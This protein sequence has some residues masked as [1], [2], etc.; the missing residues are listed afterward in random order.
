VAT[1][2]KIAAFMLLCGSLW[3]Q[4]P[5]LK[6]RPQISYAPIRDEQPVHRNLHWKRRLFEAGTGA[7]AA[8]LA[9]DACDGIIGAKKA[10]YVGAA[11]FVL[12]FGIQELWH[13]GKK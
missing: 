7:L 5:E 1:L 6:V 11:G 2:A 4:S 3:A 9:D 8:K 13:R 12:N 10:R